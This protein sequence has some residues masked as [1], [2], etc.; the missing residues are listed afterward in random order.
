MASEGGTSG[1]TSDRKKDIAWVAGSFGLCSAFAA[2]LF[3]PYLLPQMKNSG[4]VVLVGL[5]LLV[6]V[7]LGALGGILGS[8][9]K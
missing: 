6:G 9:A 2:Y 8:K 5:A 3:I 7:V 4:P 1:A